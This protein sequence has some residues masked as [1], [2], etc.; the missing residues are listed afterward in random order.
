M[1]FCTIL[2]SMENINHTPP[3]SVKSPATP[4]FAVTDAAFARIA[5]LLSDE[6]DGTAF[7]IEVLG[8]GCSGFQYH[9]DLLNKP[10]TDDDTVFQQG[11]AI[12]VIDDVS[13]DIMQGSTLDYTQD[14]ASAGFEI[15]NPNVTAS[16]G[17][18]NSFAM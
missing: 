2:I 16:C 8:G 17:C 11:S 15:T 4:A 12:V 6:P 5:Y 13:L 3:L 14:L 18:G 9:F 10:V 1:F 7:W